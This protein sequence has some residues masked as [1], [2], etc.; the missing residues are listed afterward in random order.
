MELDA[1][2][3]A[4]GDNA[5]RTIE[6]QRPIEMIKCPKSSETKNRQRKNQLL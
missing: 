6:S 5:M 3:E 1:G 2:L 4:I